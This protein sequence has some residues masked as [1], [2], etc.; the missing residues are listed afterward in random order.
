MKNIIKDFDEKYANNSV[1]QFIKFNLASFTISALQ[2]LLA[3]VLP[4]IFDGFNV[5]LP[6]F[7]NNIFGNTVN[8]VDKK[9]VVDNVLTW[10]YVLPFF[11]SNFLANIYGYFINMRYTF[12]GKGNK[13]SMKIY[14]VVLFTLIVVSTWIQSAVD[15]FISKTAFAS[16]SRTIAGLVAGFIQMIV[17][18]PLEKSV[19]FK[20]K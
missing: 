11:L 12:K 18:F 3:N 13:N 5:K 17:L 15:I 6:L 10:G 8:Y 7:I 1:W 14:L 19:L 9:Y 4:L 2:L 16:L 20:E